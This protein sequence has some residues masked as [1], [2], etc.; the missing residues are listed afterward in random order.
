MNGRN[1]IG[2]GWVEGLGHGF[3]SENPATGEVI[4]RGYSADNEQI[5]K[6]VHVAKC[7]F[8]SWSALS[9]EKRIDYLEQFCEALKKN[10]RLLATTI[11]SETGKPLWE[12]DTEVAAMIN[13]LPISVKAYHDR[14]QTHNQITP[15][16]ISMIRHRP[17][18]IVAVLGPFNFPGH[19]PNGHI[20]PALL[21]GNTIVF[22]PSE[23]TPW[24]AEKMFICWEQAGLPEGV[25]NLVHG[26]KETG[27]I[28]SR[29]PDLNG[30]MFTG[31]FKTGH[32]L[33]TEFAEKPEKILA[34]EMGGNNP[35]VVHEVN[36]IKA[37]ALRVIQSAYI[38]AGQ[39]CTCARRLILTK[40][41]NGKGFIEEL[42]KMT[43][44]LKIGPYTD[45][46]E[47]FMGPLISNIAADHVITAYDLLIHEGATP[48]VPLNRMHENLSFLSPGLL[49]VSTVRVHMD[50]EIFGPLLQL[51]W[52]DDFD[53]A[54]IEANKTAYGLAAGLL[55]DNEERYQQFLYKIKAG[56]VNWNQPLT[57]AS[58]SAPFG[59]LGHSGNHRPSA[60]YAADYCAY[61]VAS[62]EENVL[63]MPDNLP[64]GIQ[65]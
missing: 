65:L 20:I 64:P 4:W 49:D 38:T 5:N 31:S 51:M 16:G 61:P 41:W 3:T 45:N 48:L 42:I 26:G 52:V 35:L 62:L 22:K 11:A 58:S 54:L 12:S 59:G 8:P 19:L 47:P 14:C 10:R 55:C 30:L 50:E 9:L 25:I 17:H 44:T 43:R 63:K 15:S 29:H 6:A 2:S 53:A 27:K 36:D 32:V 37:A 57:G 13:K 40:G 7:A 23:L 21:A 24:V 28:L 33:A 39:R 1:F 46:P 56:V 60:Y 34:L 18:G